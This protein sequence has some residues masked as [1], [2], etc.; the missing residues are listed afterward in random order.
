[1]IKNAQN[2]EINN[3]LTVNRSLKLIELYGQA[4]YRPLMNNI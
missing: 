2:V 3:T 1:M 4:N